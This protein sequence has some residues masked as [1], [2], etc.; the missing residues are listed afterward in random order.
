MRLLVIEIE[1]R[2]INNTSEFF[3][4][5]RMSNVSVRRVDDCAS[6]FEIRTKHIGYQLTYV[7]SLRSIRVLFNFMPKLLLLFLFTR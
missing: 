6:R 2:E 5:L 3:Q 4:V 7:Q 1:I